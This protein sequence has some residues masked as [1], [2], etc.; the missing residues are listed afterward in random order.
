VVLPLRLLLRRAG[1]GAICATV[2][3]LTGAH[4][5][6]AAT[7]LPTLTAVTSAAPEAIGEVAGVTYDERDGGYSAPLGNGTSLWL[8]GDSQIVSGAPTFSLKRFVTGSTAAIGPT[9]PGSTLQ[10]LRDVVVGHGLGTTSTVPNHFLPNPTSLPLPAG[11]SG[12][13]TNSGQHFPV[14]WP[15]GAVGLG[16]A[17]RVLVTYV[18]ACVFSATS[19]SVQG[20][21]IAVFNASTF[22]FGTPPTD[23]VPPTT[24]PQVTPRYFWGSPVREPNG[25]LDVFAA[26]NDALSGTTLHVAQLLPTAK[27]LIDPSHYRPLTAL[28]ADGNSFPIG[29]FSIGLYP[30]SSGPVFRAVESV[31][32]GGTVIIWTASRATGPWTALGR[33]TLPGCTLASLYCWTEEGHPELSSATSLVVTYYRPGDPRLGLGHLAAAAISLTPPPA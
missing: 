12:A 6:R 2:A 1:L 21:G 10:G 13:C 18:D 11:Q 33:A 15:T 5:V 3:V 7:P 22:T 32:H 25:V 14:R 23:I 20:S 16:S 27:S 24:A 31:D 30:S 9:Q 4:G 26:V 28:P 17:Q 19:Y 29:T 8:F